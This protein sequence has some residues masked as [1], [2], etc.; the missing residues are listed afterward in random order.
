[1]KTSTK[2]DL[3]IN[4]VNRPR[5]EN[6]DFTQDCCALCESKSTAYISFNFKHVGYMLVCKKCLLNMVE[7]IN[8][9]ILMDCKLKG[10]IRNG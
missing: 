1:M 2:I 5:E 3:L 9:T 8:R 4:S 6:G 7:H 10:I